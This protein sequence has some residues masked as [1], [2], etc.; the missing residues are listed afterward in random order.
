MAGI[1]VTLACQPFSIFCTAFYSSIQ[2]P[3][4]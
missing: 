2:W 4:L 3:T 1:V